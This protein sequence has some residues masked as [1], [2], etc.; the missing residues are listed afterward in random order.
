MDV[1]TTALMTPRLTNGELKI[2]ALNS[3]F[4]LFL[5]AHPSI[6]SVLQRD[7]QPGDE[8]CLSFQ[9]QK[10]L[11]S[12]DKQ[13]TNLLGV[14]RI[15]NKYH[16]D[17]LAYKPEERGGDALESFEHLVRDFI[18]ETGCI[19]N[20]WRHIRRVTEDKDYPDTCCGQDVKFSGSKKSVVFMATSNNTAER[21]YSI[22]EKVDLFERQETKAG[23]RGATCL[24]CSEKKAIQAVSIPQQMPDMFVVTFA[25]HASTVRD[26]TSKISWGGSIYQTI[27]VIHHGDN[28]FW[29]SE[30]DNGH[31]ELWWRIDDYCNREDTWKRR[32]VDGVGGLA[33]SPDGG[34]IAHKL[35]EKVGLI[36]LQ[37][38]V[39]TDEDEDRDVMQE[40]RDSTEVAQVT[41][42]KYHFLSN[43]FQA[44]LQMSTMIS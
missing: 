11:C 16:P 37:K 33:T 13:G 36:L 39:A 25:P 7:R 43:F 22:Q 32:Y 5:K 30:M 10:V 3:S 19:G 23:V 1:E 40:P 38:I 44:V 31:E 18:Q 20:Q 35:N 6:R 42:M 27:A 28:H 41:K 12:Q 4:L 24:I 21:V 34:L 14:K 2:C 29:V 8:D 9:I 17:T 15:L 26:L